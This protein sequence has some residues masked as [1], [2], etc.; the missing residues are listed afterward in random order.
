MPQYSNLPG[1]NRI[2]NNETYR[3]G[4]G[5]DYVKN[6]QIIV[7]V[8]QPRILEDHCRSLAD[9]RLNIFII[10]LDIITYFSVKKDA[11]SFV[12]PL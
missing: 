2:K 4:S 10:I 5:C 9:Y 1:V 3:Q 12:N 8:P 6:I 11:S 7:M